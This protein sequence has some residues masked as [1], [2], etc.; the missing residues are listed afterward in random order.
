MKHHILGIVL[1]CLLLFSL[2]ACAHQEIPAW[3]DE[4][5]VPIDLRVAIG[6]E[7]PTAEDFLS[8][9]ARARCRDQGWTIEFASLPDFD[10]PGTHSV[11]LLLRDGKKNERQL[12]TRVVVAQDTT[13]PVLLGVKEI[14]ACVG[15]GLILREGVTATDD[16][17][18]AITWTVDATAVDTTKEG[19]YSATYTAT[20]ASGNTSQK[21]V[22]VHIWA[23]Q[24]T[25]KMLWDKLDP[26]LAQL[27][28]PHATAEQ[29]CRAIHAY[30]Q[31]NIGYF[32]ISDKTDPVRAAYDALFGKGRGDC[33]SY[34]SAAMMMLERSEIAYLEIERVHEEGQET[35]FWLM[36]NL[37]SAGEQDRW[38]H[39]DPTLVSGGGA[40]GQGCLFTDAQLDEYNAIDPGFYDY[41]RT[42]YPPTSA[43]VITP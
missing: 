10:T 3:T 19:I 24:V 22:Y 43:D 34:F 2:L 29:K 13:P 17:F 8:D 37:A 36:V 32:P 16:C 15:E 20:D 30:V 26:I 6:G 18:G 21:T 40:A 25:Q 39:F 9:E 33:Y 35:H 7:R 42:A 4:D 31:E 27:F 23:Q 11:T 28:P 5:L 1:T 41:D 14:S 12:Q 38:Y